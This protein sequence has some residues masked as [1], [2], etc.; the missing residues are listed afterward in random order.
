VVGD[1]GDCTG[2]PGV[3]RLVANSGEMATPVQ[4]LVVAKLK[5]TV[6]KSMVTLWRHPAAL[7]YV[8]IN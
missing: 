3:L 7:S 4:G 1:Q 8:L 6:A 5:D 2:G